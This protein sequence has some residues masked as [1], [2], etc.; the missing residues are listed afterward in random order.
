MHLGIPCVDPI[1]YP[2]VHDGDDVCYPAEAPDGRQWRPPAAPYMSVQDH[3]PGFARACLECCNL[4]T[5]DRLMTGW[6]CQECAQAEASHRHDPFGLVAFWT[7]FTLATESMT[8]VDE[9][10]WYR[11]YGWTVT[12]LGHPVAPLQVFHDLTAA[13]NHVYSLGLVGMTSSDHVRHYLG[14]TF[15]KTVEEY[16]DALAAGLVPADTSTISYVD[17]IHD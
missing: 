1:I 16:R 6:L 3:N 17:G 5:N 15:S 13:C 10:R 7:R 9:F 11:W 4:Y 12:K 8:P 14:R 2:P